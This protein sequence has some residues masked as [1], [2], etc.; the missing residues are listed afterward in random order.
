MTLR[1]ATIDHQAAL[2]GRWKSVL[3]FLGVSS[4]YLTGRHGPCPICR[5]GK[6]RF[7]FDDKEGKGTWICSKCGA[8]DGFKLLEKVNGWS[9]GY[10]KREAMKA[11]GTAPAETQAPGRSAEDKRAAALRL[12]D[13][14]APIKAADPA[15]LFLRRR[16]I[17]QIPSPDVLRFAKCAYFEDGKMIARLPAMVAAVTGPDG[18]LATVHRT[19]LDEH[20][21]KTAM[22]GGARKL[23]A[24]DLPP[25]S[26][27][28][29]GE[30]EGI[31]GV[32][33][34][35]ETALSA[36]I[37]FGVPVWACINKVRLQ[38][39]IPPQTVNT[40]IVFGDTDEKFGGQAHAYGL[41]HRVACAGL[42]VRVELPGEGDWNDV[43]LSRGA[44]HG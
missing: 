34:G 20:G 40:L 43:L 36:E 29:L 11:S 14:S 27:V 5:E 15:G 16:G 12:W 8:G 41:A 3:P 44:G 25:G 9:F 13:S 33:E 39:F 21:H 30:H 23:A 4:R 10:A 7:R 18:S 24:G 32:A 35:I 2:Q 19:Y 1:F 38:S 37:L 31:L 26:A 42:K 6:D 17:T 28:R 22:Q